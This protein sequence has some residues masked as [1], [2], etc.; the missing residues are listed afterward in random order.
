MHSIRDIC[1]LHCLHLLSRWC[2]QGRGI[3]HPYLHISLSLSM[4]LE[5]RRISWTTC[6]D[7]KSNLSDLKEQLS[8]VNWIACKWEI[9][10]YHHLPGAIINRMYDCHL[11]SIALDVK[12]VCLWSRRY[13]SDHISD[14]GSLVAAE[15]TS[16]MHRYWLM[17]P[18]SI[19]M[20]THRSKLQ[21]T[22]P[23]EYV[24][25]KDEKT[26]RLLYTHLQV[27]V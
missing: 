16:S 13:S 8:H 15:Y 20:T 18:Q 11:H 24:E 7:V 1:A 2:S 6:G 21:F 5:R 3:V 26:L 12:G 14:N 23:V 17:M 22:L 19:P 25:D 10:I 9:E 27:S 4:A